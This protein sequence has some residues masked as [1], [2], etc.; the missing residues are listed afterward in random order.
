MF[1][2][3]THVSCYFFVDKGEKNITMAEKECEKLGA[4]LPFIK[5]A[6]EN[7]FLLN[8]MRN[9][10]F[11]FGMQAPQKENI[12]YWADGTPVATTYSNWNEGEPNYKGKE[13]CGYMY[14]T[15]YAPGEW[16]NN[17]CSETWHVLCL[18]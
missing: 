9:R 3:N 6:K 15:T 17:P 2:S 4:T 5:S 10:N 13:N 8:L 7:R 14:T 16:N 11:W 12:F 1:K 18:K